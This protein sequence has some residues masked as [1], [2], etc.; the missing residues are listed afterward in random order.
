MRWSGTLLWVAGVLAARAAWREVRTTHGPV[1]GYLRSSPAHY[2][3][4]G[5]PYGARPP[6]HDRFGP[7]RPPARRDG[8]YEAVHRTRCP[9]PRARRTDDDCLAVN[10][11]APAGA[12]DLPVMVHVHDGRFLTG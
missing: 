4:L 9:Q 8:I 7:P 11:F 2:A 6:R 12:R 1:R 5:I 10:V 3:Y